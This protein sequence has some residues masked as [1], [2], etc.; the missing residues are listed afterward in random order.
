MAGCRGGLR[1]ERGMGLAGVPMVEVR[2]TVR[3]MPSLADIK[4]SYIKTSYIKTS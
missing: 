2:W 3:G 1:R 4:T